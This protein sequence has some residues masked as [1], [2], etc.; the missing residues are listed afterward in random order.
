MGKNKHHQSYL[1]IEE[2]VISDANK[3]TMRI[4]LIDRES[5]HRANEIRT[6]EM[7]FGCIPHA[8]P[9]NKYN[10]ILPRMA[11]PT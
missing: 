9:W 4:S 3:K 1:W 5:M 11:L 2:D 8:G 10:A 6:F 7:L